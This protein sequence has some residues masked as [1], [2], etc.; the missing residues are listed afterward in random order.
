MSAYRLAAAETDLVVAYEN[1][2]WD[3]GQRPDHKVLWGARWFCVHVGEPAAF[4]ELP[5]TD[6]LAV[7]TAQ[8][9]LQLRDPRVLLGDPPLLRGVDLYQ[10]QHQRTQL[11]HRGRQVRRRAAGH[12]GP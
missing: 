6:Q 3:V 8:P 12:H 2:L 7:N 1:D 10:L 9:P 11:L 5:M 4:P